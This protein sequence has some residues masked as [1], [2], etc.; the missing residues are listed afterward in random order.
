MEF[1]TPLFLFLFLPVFVFVY[2]LAA[3]RGK[4]I[5]GILGSL[6]FYA[7]GNLDHIPLMLGLT[8]GTYFLAR[9]MDRWRGQR[10]SSIM[11]WA[12]VLINVIL[13]IGFKVREDIAYPLG[14]SYVTFQVI[15]YLFEVHNGSLES[16]T[17]FI[18][19]S[20]Y[21]LL[22]PKIPVG[23]IARY[24][25]LKKEI[26]ELRTDPIGMADGL[27][28]FIRGL[29]KK[30]LIAD[31]LAK[32][33][34]PI[35]NLTSPIISP[36]LA[37]LVLIGFTLQLYFDFSGYSDM[38][39]GL[40]RML[41][42]KFPENFNFPYLSKSIGDFWRR[43]HMS[44]SSWFRDF[45]FFPMERRRLPWFGQ[46]V[47]ILA[48]F[49]LTGLWHGLTRNFVLWG[50]LHGLALVFETTPLGRRVTALRSP[51]SNLYTLSVIAVGWVI[52]RSPTPD[53]ALDFLRRLLGDTAGL[54]IL[55]FH[56]T[57]P[58]P[59]IEPT[60]VLALI[61]GT[62]FSFPTGQWIGRLFQGFRSRKVDVQIFKQIV[63]D[64]VLILLLVASISAGAALAFTPGIYGTF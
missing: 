44:L 10:L 20:F 8:V 31:T 63:Y 25:Q 37:W 32:T 2:H 48:V 43:W 64:S 59:M 62:I 55:P 24:S 53:F 16:E 52:F 21:L 46:P 38:A 4:L 45:V 22:F 33:V 3:Q 6:L 23:P 35:F 34:N 9:G 40:G 14:L 39:I 51:F 58:L 15:A 47:N 50:L 54:R 41:G 13:L 61:A 56:L 60:F 17:D 18:K 30:V 28:R 7:W 29:A 42:L 5:L 49:I 12:G 36:S 27:R 19:F 1:N 11:L 57:S 26:A